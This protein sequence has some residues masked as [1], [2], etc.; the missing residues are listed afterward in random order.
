M[1]ET[2]QRNWSGRDAGG[3]LVA[4]FVRIDGPP[5]PPG[6]RE[7]WRTGEDDPDVET[8]AGTMIRWRIL[9]LHDLPFSVDSQARPCKIR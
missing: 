6:G 1:R 8:K 4:L 2:T 5:T 3:N 7:L 9:D